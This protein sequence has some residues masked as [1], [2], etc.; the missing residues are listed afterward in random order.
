MVPTIVSTMR[1]EMY[2]LVFTLTAEERL[3][4]FSHFHRYQGA[5]DADEDILIS[6]LQGA[7]AA[8]TC[9]GV[10]LTDRVIAATNLRIIA[11]AAGSVKGF[12]S[13][14]WE[15]GIAVT[16]AAPVIAVA[17][18]EM[19]LA[20]T[21]A[22]LRHFPA[23]QEAFRHRGLRGD[24][25]IQPR[26][27]ANRSLHGLKVGIVGASATG[28]EFLKLLKAF[29]DV[30]AWIYDPYLSPNEAEALGVAKAELED[31]LTQCD[32]VSLH[33]P[34]LP[35]TH[36][37]INARTASMLKDGAVLINTAR[38]AL[39]DHDALLP[40]LQSGRISAGLDVYL[41]TL[42]GEEAVAQSPYRDLDNVVITPGIAGPA[43]TVTKRMSLFVAEE[44]ERFF[45]G[46]PLHK[47]VTREALDHIA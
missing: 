45:S 5:A 41:E 22:C 30:E 35:E 37:L 31:L 19:A 3:R 15:R 43:G 17:V 4:S 8:I 13:A 24:P 32:V 7:D 46:R 42:S 10:R 26:L 6:L 12:P 1:D 33:C 20:L 21:L 14:V 36:H 34:S 40:H 28:R 47:Q 9:W 2:D 27:L 25:S 16:H 29:G 11:H 18:G 39:V 38:G 23:H 44:L